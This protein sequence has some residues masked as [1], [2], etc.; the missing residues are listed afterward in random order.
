MADPRELRFGAPAA[1]TR[2][3]ANPD[4]GALTPRERELVE[5]L[6]SGTTTDRELA[7]AL[8]IGRNTLKYHF[9]NVLAK[10]GLRNRAQVVA[11]VLRRPAERWPDDEESVG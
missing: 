7:V 6:V 3:T 8:G 11:Y 1:R 10:L 5:H 4:L 2:A 9:R